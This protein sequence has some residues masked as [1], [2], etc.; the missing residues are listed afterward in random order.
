MI[1]KRVSFMR[2]DRS[3]SQLSLFQ[4]SLPQSN[5]V[6]RIIHYLGSKLR[7]IQPIRDAMAEVTPPGG[8]I[9]DLFAGSGAVALGLSERWDVVAVDIQEY[10]RVLCSAI[11]FPPNDA[12][13]GARLLA[14][15]ARRSALRTT[16]RESLQPLLSFESACLERAKAGDA[17]NLCNLL[18]HGSL[19]LFEFRGVLPVAE[20]DS[21]ARETLR[22]LSD[23]HLNTGPGTVVTRHFGELFLL[24][25]GDRF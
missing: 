8:T 13:S 1:S 22:R 7:I 5:R 24:G 2:H 25:A 15:E 23:A 21:G 18:E 14:N 19:P 12:A 6:P 3:V 4:D 9:C 11:L 20:L 17:E 16:L 10:S